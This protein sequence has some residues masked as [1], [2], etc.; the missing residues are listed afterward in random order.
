[1]TI[2]YSR[3]AAVATRLLKDPGA[4]QLLLKPVLLTGD[5]SALRTRAGRSMFLASLSL[6]TRF[7][8]VVH[9]YVGSDAFQQR[10]MDLATRIHF[11]GAI[12]FLRKEDIDWKD[13]GAIL[14]V[15]ATQRRDLPWTSIACQ[16]WA[17][18]VCSTGGPVELSFQ[19]F[20]PAS[21]LVAAS[22][23]STEVFKRLLGV[24]PPLGALFENE[25]FSL[26]T[27]TANA[28][29][30]PDMSGPMRLDCIL[31]GHGAIG[32]AIRHVLL[33][34]PLEGWLAVIDNQKARE[35]NW[36]TNIDLLPGQFGI[37]KARLATLGWSSGV[38]PVH[39]NMS[40]IA[41][42]ALLGTKIPYPDLTLSGLDNVEAR[43]D[44]Q[45]FWPDI[46]IDGAIGDVTCQVSRH[47]WQA[48]TACLQCLFRQPPAE[49][50]AV[51]AS[52][53]TGLT[54][55]SASRQQEVVTQAD[56]DAAAGE[57]KVWLAARKGHLKCSVIREA[58]AA[59]LT[60]R[61]SEFSPSAPFVAS[62]SGA[63]VAAEFIKARMGLATPLDPRFQFNLLRGLAAGTLLDQSRRS[64]CFCSERHSAIERW[65]VTARQFSVRVPKATTVEYPLDRHF[66]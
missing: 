56:I 16:G 17:I 6:L 26:L 41:A 44:L 66:S 22:L 7:C 34:L 24:V 33:E 53:A 54:V 43:H 18:Q 39:F 28:D 42:Q 58:L 5:T 49:D 4:G 9:V 47:P 11:A 46:A 29:P 51:V 50:A 36:G 19:R 14:N 23:G 65:R 57:K 10:A 32:S 27:Y 61:P 48:D 8:G 15:G 25:V 30:G 63:M 40:V 62:L 37:S 52:R 55:A 45:L 64:T 38:V 12:R 2:A 35:E 13:Y 3:P 20:N 59:H 60:G 1:M 21:T 31:A